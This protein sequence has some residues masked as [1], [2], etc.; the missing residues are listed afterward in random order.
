MSFGLDVRHALRRIRR[1]PAQAA[2]AVV[3]LA[4]GLAVSATLF[5]VTRD[6]VFHPFP[7]RDPER[8]A[9]IW[10]NDVPR[11]VPRLELT[12]FQFEQIG[13]RARSFD[14]VA[15]MS[16]ANFNVIVNIP[17]PHQVVANFTTESF[18]R[19]T[20]MTAAIG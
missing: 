13:K 19:V 9:A 14:G 2:L 15:L 17:E 4:I 5:T 20:G 12:Y 3:T 8:L 6:V 16:A 11:G 7:F 1:R 10:S 18:P